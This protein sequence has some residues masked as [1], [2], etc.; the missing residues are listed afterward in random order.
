MRAKHR[1]IDIPRSTLCIMYKYVQICAS[2]T[3]VD[4]LL[5]GTPA[6]HCTFVDRVGVAIYKYVLYMTGG[7]QETLI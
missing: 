3:T 2:V 5:C 1:P 6:L 4:V 7:A